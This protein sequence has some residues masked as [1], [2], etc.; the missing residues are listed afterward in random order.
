MMMESKKKTYILGL[1]HQFI[2][3]WDFEMNHNVLFFLET[4]LNILYSQWNTILQVHLI[5]NL[6]Q[7]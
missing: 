3:R 1:L 6:I 2:Q 7:A 5:L 4:W